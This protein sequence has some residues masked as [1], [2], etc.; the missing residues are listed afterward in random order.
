[1][2][3]EHVQRFSLLAEKVASMI[4]Y[5]LNCAQHR[6]HDAARNQRHSEMV[7]A[8]RMPPA[9]S[10]DHETVARLRRAHAAL[11]DFVHVVQG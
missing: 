10:L 4:D 7:A 5:H 11:I 9:R 2:T 8:G 6:P 1:M 3:T